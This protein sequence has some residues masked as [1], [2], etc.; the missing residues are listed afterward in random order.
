MGRLDG[1]QQWLDEQFAR[2]VGGSG[3]P[4]ASIAILAGDE[5][6]ERATGVLNLRT[7]VAA[8][9]DSVF[10]I[11]SITKVWT[12]TLVLQLVD[13]GL[14]DLDEP[15]RTYLPA[16]R[17]ADD[18]ASMI[19]T[20]R[21][22][23]S[24]T[25]GLEGDLFAEIGRDDDIEAD[26]DG[27]LRRCLRVQNELADQLQR[28]APRRDPIVQLSRDTFS[29]VGTSR[30]DA[31]AFVGDDGLGRAAFVHSGGRATPRV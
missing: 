9:T 4:S 26:A 27:G 2:L 10:Q 16:F 12:A 15:V 31:F 23:L 29:T 6:V 17:V 18:H 5:V 20:P 19:I 21:H 3:I 7:G 8:T 24:H 28:P 30:N 25:S 1:V 14:L 22:L 11:G 13:E